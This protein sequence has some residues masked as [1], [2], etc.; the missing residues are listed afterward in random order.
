MNSQ[1]DDLVHVWP[2]IKNVFSVPHTEEECQNLV[3]I[4][5]DLV[6][7][8]GENENHPLASL[9]ESIGT[10][11]ET[12]EKNT[13]V[14]TFGNSIDTLHYLMDE[15]GL[16]QSDLPEIGS[17]GVVSEILRGKR[18]LNIRQIKKLSERFSVSPL[19]F[20]QDNQKKCNDV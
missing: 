12:Y 3:S 19:V 10:L 14:D 7:E 18:T 6:D 9:M 11:I 5:D 16:K 1:V 4:V 15:H 13:I 17:Q 2:K 20:I 8:V